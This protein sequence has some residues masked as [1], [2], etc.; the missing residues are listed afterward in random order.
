LFADKKSN[1]GKFCTENTTIKIRDY[2]KRN[3]KTM[4]S[5]RHWQQIAKD[6]C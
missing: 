4:K 3:S 2:I 1:L 6:T 5:K